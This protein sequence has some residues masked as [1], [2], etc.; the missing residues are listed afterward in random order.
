VQAKE[1]T[2]F[3]R[4]QYAERSGSELTVMLDWFDVKSQIQ[5]WAYH[6]RW[7]Y[8]QPISGPLISRTLKAPTVLKATRRSQ[9]GE[10]AQ[11]SGQLS[12]IKRYIR[13]T[14]ALSSEQVAHVEARL[15][16]AEEAS[17]R[18]GRKE[19]VLLFGGAVLALILTDTITPDVAQHILSMALHGLAHLFV[20]GGAATLRGL[21]S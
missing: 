13:E 21:N 18:M 11:I 16:Q 15:D 17:H 5:Q 12:E 7:Q 19:W 3:G 2:Y 6:I 20:E 9:P 14:K 1:V 10:L 8:C 4:Y